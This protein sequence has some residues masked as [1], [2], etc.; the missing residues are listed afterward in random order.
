MIRWLAAIIF[1]LLIHAL[2]I[3]SYNFF[4]NYDLNVKERKVTG[5]KFLPAEKKQDVIN[6]IQ[7]KS[8]EPKIAQSTEKQPALVQQKKDFSSYISEELL[9]EMD[10]QNLD[11]VEEISS[12]VINDLQNI[13]IEPNN[14]PQGVYADFSLELDRLGNI[15]SFKLIR[16]SGIGAFDRAAQNA[17]RKY[18]KIKYIAEIDQ[19]LYSTYFEKFTIRFIPK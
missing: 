7:K 2:I 1:S 19:S 18:N 10:Q 13:W 4:Q 15:I 6:E 8:T 5:V 14:L 9:M 12:K 17:I 16:S 11:L 3:F